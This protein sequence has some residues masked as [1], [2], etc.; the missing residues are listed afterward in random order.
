L[1]AEFSGVARARADGRLK[2]AVPRGTLF[3]ETV[4]ALERAGVE[5]VVA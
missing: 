3:E 4:A 5:V 1:S 2:L